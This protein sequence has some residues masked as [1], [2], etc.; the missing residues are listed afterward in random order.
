[1]KFKNISLYYIL[2]PSLFVAAIILGYFSY[3]NAIHFEALGEQ[4]IVESMLSIANDKI[5]RIEELII[6]SDN[7][8]FSIGEMERFEEL[9]I[10]WDDIKE[11]SQFI[12]NII[13]LDSN[14]DILLFLYDSEDS[15]SNSY[16]RTFKDNILPLIK[17]E[18]G[19]INEHK[20][21]HGKI[22][23]KYY[24]ISYKT[25]FYH[26]MEYRIFINNNV[27]IFVREIFP[28]LLSDPNQIQL[29]NIIDDSG[30]LIFGSALKV[31]GEYS[32]V[33]SFPTT[34]YHWR[35]QI[36]PSNAGELIK[37]ARNKK[38][39]D[40][41]L[42]GL[43]LGIIVFGLSL[44][45]YVT[46]KERK[47]NI[48]KNDFIS[49]FSH[50]LKTPLSLI[51][52][53]SE[54]LV[55]GKVDKEEKKKEYYEI[56]NRETER[57]SSL[58]DNVLDFSRLERGKVQYQFEKIFINILLEDIISIYKTRF[59]NEHIELIMKIEDNL[60]PIFVDVHSIKIAIHNLLDNALKYASKSEHV[61]IEVNKVALNI[62]I[63]IRD[64]GEG[65]PK[66]EQKKIFERF[67]R[68]V[69]ARTQRG[70]GIGLNVA[71]SIVESHGGKIWV[72]S[73]PRKGSN[74]IIR[75]PITQ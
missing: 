65:I 75:L 10:K 30:K 44:F 29:I 51:K 72:E 15:S 2:F 64:E 27:E 3:K 52:M 48:L 49:N 53:F 19:D 50:E 59:E 58:I 35:L 54:L 57:L 38:V 60:P 14:D 26:D 6:N 73:E 5:D 34:F 7:N 8:V 17:E 46:F 25:F 1:M 74:F 11:N 43:S 66:E 55:M 4:Y 18:M 37:R 21:W 36:S 12:N 68:S 56:I 39:S 69:Q 33:R 31:W 45:S 28:L 24:L 32:V 67:Y 63:K 40:A 71:K 62:E 70:S 41:I 42:I 47:L 16:I 23:S 61:W 9:E 13:V 20:H 22:G